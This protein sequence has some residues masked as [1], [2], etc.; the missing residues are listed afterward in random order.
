MNKTL[1]R[2]RISQCW[3]GASE[4]EKQPEKENQKEHKGERTN[5]WEEGQTLLNLHLLHPLMQQHQLQEGQTPS[6][7]RGI[8][9]EFGGAKSCYVS[10]KS[11]RST[12]MKL[13]L[14]APPIK[15]KPQKIR[16][17]SGLF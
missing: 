2:F 5:I 10:S 14:Q 9:R 1:L 16:Q 3:V 4:G 13:R 7:C 8:R 12:S 11:P 15:S 6:L 17:K